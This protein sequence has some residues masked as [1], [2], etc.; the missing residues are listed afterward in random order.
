VARGLIAKRQFAD[1]E[2]ELD[3]VVQAFPD[4]AAAWQ[5]LGDDLL[6]Q[7]RNAE[8]RRAYLAATEHDSTYAAPHLSLA[9]L[10]AAEKNWQDALD[11]SDAL[12]KLDSTSS[13]AY[14]YKAVANYNLAS[15][16]KAFDCAQ[17]AVKLD[18]AHETPLAELLLGLL[19][20]MRGDDKTAAEQFRNY[21]LHAPPGTNV[22]EARR[23]L[24]E[25]E[26]HIA[27]SGPK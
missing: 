5:E 7:N 17:Q 27:A 3:R 19:C 11:E 2:K 21:L 24:A 26:S 9:R 23:R 25:A 10:S 16:D 13:R 22:D 12:L 6:F 1:A 4:Y 8:A 15:Y 20:S 18:A 14:Y